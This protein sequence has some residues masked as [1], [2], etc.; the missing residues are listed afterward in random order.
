MENGISVGTVRKKPFIFALL[1][2]LMAM[3][4]LIGSFGLSGTA[5]ALPLGGIG[6]FIVEFDELQGSGFQLLPHIGETGDSAQAPMVRNKM[7]NATI[8][9]LHIYKDLKLPGGKWVRFHIR[10][11]GEATVQGLI[12][13][14]RFIKANLSFQEL[15]IKEKNTDDFSNN[16]TQEAG[17]ISITEAKLVTDYLFQSMVSLKGAKISV[18]FIDGPERIEQ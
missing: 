12:Q 16:W 10:S 6:D 18:E 17:T 1:G 8:K 11:E 15:H 3:L 13:D 2:G 9:G 5:L 4:L 14:A 7:D